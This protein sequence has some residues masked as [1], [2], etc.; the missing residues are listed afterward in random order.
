VTDGT[1]VPSGTNLGWIDEANGADVTSWRV[2]SSRFNSSHVDSQRL[3]RCPV[4][5]KRGLQLPLAAV[6]TG[7]LLSASSVN[8]Q[9][10]LHQTNESV[11]Q[12]TRREAAVRYLATVN[13]AQ[14]AS[15]KKQGAYLPLDE[16]S[17]IA[18]VPVG[19]LPRLFFDR[20][21][22]LVSLKDFFDPCGFTLFSDDRGVIYE[23]H[24]SAING[25]V[26]PTARTTPASA[27]GNGEPVAAEDEPAETGEGSRGAR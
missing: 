25:S 23:S 27:G 20:W 21:G 11:N 8:A 14:A 7:L 13:E 24:P 16:A 9:D 12:R 5:G 22:Y 18:S 15:Q 10:C 2:V 1:K 17:G 26:T 6:V 19:F 4:L 3:G